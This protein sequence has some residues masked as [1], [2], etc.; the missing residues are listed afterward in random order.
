M[1]LPF[2]KLKAMV[3]KEPVGALDPLEP[4]TDDLPVK[5]KKKGKGF[6]RSQFGKAQPQAGSYGQAGY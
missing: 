2:N 3:T 6:K 4:D 5:P 1:K